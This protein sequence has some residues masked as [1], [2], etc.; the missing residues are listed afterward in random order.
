M[1][2]PNDD[3]P[4]DVDTDP[5]DPAVIAWDADAAARQARHNDR[6]RAARDAATDD[7]WAWSAT[8]ATTTTR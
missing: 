6:V 3:H 7:P 8:V 4:N 5:A 2:T 1:L